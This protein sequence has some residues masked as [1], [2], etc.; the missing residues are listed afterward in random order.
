MSFFSIYLIVAVNCWLV[1]GLLIDPPRLLPYVVAV[2]CMVSVA[3]ASWSNKVRLRTRADTNIRQRLKVFYENPSDDVLKGLPRI[4][5]RTIVDQH[6]ET[7]LQAANLS[8][9]RIGTHTLV[10]SIFFFLQ[11]DFL[12]LGF[13]AFTDP[14][15]LSAAC[16]NSALVMAFAAAHLALFADSGD[17]EGTKDAVEDLQDN[18][19][20]GIQR[21][22][23]LASIQIQ[24]ANAQASSVFRVVLS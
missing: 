20:A 22:L 23:T 8:T 10:V 14:T 24:K 19:A 3:L 17:R 6:L 18:M 4:V 16:L 13:A 15:S 7:A 9:A 5:F 11:I 2:V 1:L 12:F 21:V